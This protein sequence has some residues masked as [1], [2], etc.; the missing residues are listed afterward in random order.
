M[1]FYFI[2]NFSEF[3]RVCVGVRGGKRWR[4]RAWRYE[5]AYEGYQQ[6]QCYKGIKNKVV[7]LLKPLRSGDM[8]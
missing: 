5:A 7:I 6:L 4:R 3:Q 8:A 2:I 1:H